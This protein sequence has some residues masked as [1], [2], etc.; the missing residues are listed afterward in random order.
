MSLSP[1]AYDYNTT[2]AAAATTTTTTTN[3]SI[4]QKRM[5]PMSSNLA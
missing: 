4:T 5:N 1:Y 2:A 3:Y